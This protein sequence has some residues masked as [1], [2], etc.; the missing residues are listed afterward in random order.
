[1]SIWKTF[2]ETPVERGL[3]IFRH[4]EKAAL[5]PAGGKAT[6]DNLTVFVYTW[7]EPLLTYDLV[8]CINND[9]FIILQFPLS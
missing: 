6:F 1:M 4:G 9:I 2:E 3:C 8:H 5:I 7:N